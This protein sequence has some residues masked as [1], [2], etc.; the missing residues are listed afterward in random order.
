[1]L[2]NAGACSITTA[3]TTTTTAAPSPLHPSYFVPLLL[4]LDFLLSR[5]LKWKPMLRQSAVIISFQSNLI[6]V[7]LSQPPLN[8]LLIMEKSNFAILSR[9]L[10]EVWLSWCTSWAAIGVFSD[11][12]WRLPL[13]IRISHF[14]PSLVYFPLSVRFEASPPLIR[15]LHCGVIPIPE[16]AL[17]EPAGWY[18]S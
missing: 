13:T 15:R 10:Q 16:Y 8:R 6:N 14:L 3:T 18:P 7:R 2:N 11:M 4:L 5:P 17:I 9:R 12:A 1:M